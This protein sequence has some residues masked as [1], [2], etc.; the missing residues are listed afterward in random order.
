MITAVFTDGDDCVWAYGL[1]QWD[2]GQQLRI[3]GLH[4]PTVVE[5][6]FSLQEA[7]GEAVPRVG[8]TKDGVTTVTIPDSM[9]EGAG[10]VRD[11]QVYAWVYLSDRTF[12]E[13]TKQ[14]MMKVK[15]RSKPKAFEAPGDGEIFR[16]AI[17]A[18]NDAAKRAED[19]GDKA[20]VAADEAEKAATQ[21]AEHLQA[22][23]GLAEQVETNADTVAQDK[24]AVA[25]MLSQTQQAAS[26]AALS[27]QAAKLSETAA[28]QAQTGAE[29]AEDGARQYAEETGADRQAVANDKQVVSQMREAVA[30]DRQAVEQ[31]AAQFGQ[32]A[33][34]ALTAIGQAQSTAVGAV[35]AEGNK[36]TTA[37]QEA[38]TQAVREV[39][40]AKTTAVQAVTTE[41]DKQT[42]RVEDAAAGIIADREQINQNK[43]DIA[44][45]VE[46][47][48]D[49]APAI[50]NTASDS[51]IT[52][53]D[54]AEDRP[55]RGL[56]VFG[57]STQDG[58]PTPEAPI[59]IVS[60]GEDGS[61]EVKVTGKNL[62]TGRLYYIDYS[63]GAGFIKN[64]NE[65]SLPYAPKSET[66]G[67]GYVIPCAP[68]KHYAF[69]VTNP[70][71]NAVVAI[72]EYKTLEDAKNKENAIGFV[73]PSLASPYKSVYTSKGNG[74]LVCWIAGKWTDGKTTIHECTE[75]EL[76]QLEI[77]SEAT[78]YEPYRT[79]QILTLQT[80]NGLPGV[81][82]SKDG[83]YTDQNGQQWVCD[84]IDLGRGKYVQRIEEHILK[85]K[86]ITSITNS[87]Q[88]NSEYYGIEYNG[89]TKDFVGKFGNG[90]LCDKLAFVK[91][92]SNINGHEITY[93]TGNGIIVFGLKKSLVPSGDLDEIRNYITSNNFAFL[94]LIDSPIE[95]DLTPEEI[96][97][98]KKTHT[99]YP[100]TVITN[101]AGAHMEV[102]YVADTGIYIRNMESRLSA[103]L[104][105]IQSALISQKTSG[106]GAFNNSR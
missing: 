78:T 96:T 53:D 44:G 76:L 11:Y 104:V 66:S 23:E 32:T 16:Q 102:S 39:A 40:G 83:N 92:N 38:G 22:T 17:E 20:V 81:P 100:T 12:D 28:V 21:T 99:N 72:S 65:V 58:T 85:S 87:R 1:W 90:V 63:M 94:I 89:C 61:I 74:V 93:A 60:A 67:I 46:G 91:P 103:Q 49:L 77:G 84:E 88:I 5:I 106:G 43:A 59:P 2:Y 54:A 14:I 55:F 26:D 86:N 34:D 18:V 9:L 3:E 50:L 33:Q 73:V 56:R 15:A 70:N 79:P 95:K 29:A 7:G 30:A 98:Y 10:A 24:Q 42:K 47:M 48:T 52:A 31:T 69:S 64:E 71:E 6:H 105:N 36:Q 45:L 8:V 35:K 80:P 68:E 19:A 13:T 4:L 27:A 25:G 101:D 97:E 37:V 57:K 51:V 82:V 41:G 62:L 75:S